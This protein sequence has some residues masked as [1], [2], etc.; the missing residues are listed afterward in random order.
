MTP[1]EK[2]QL[3]RDAKKMFGTEQAQMMIQMIDLRIDK[4]MADRKARKAVVDADFEQWYAEY[5]RREGKVAARKSWEKLDFTLTSLDRMLKVLSAQKK[6]WVKDKTAKK[7]IPLPS[8]Y[9][10]QGRHFDTVK[11]VSETKKTVAYCVDCCYP[12]TQCKC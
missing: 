2:R 6:Q 5:P 1:E 10:N 11:E 12:K 9:L 4:K 7:F 3:W 8:T